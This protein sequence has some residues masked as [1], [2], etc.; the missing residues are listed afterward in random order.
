[1]S[2]VSETIDFVLAP[3]VLRS[4]LGAAVLGLALYSRTKPR[5]KGHVT[6]GLCRTCSQNYLPPLVAVFGLARIW[7]YWV[8][9]AVPEPYLVSLLVT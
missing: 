9:N 7:L 4:I 3:T 5:H 2:F 6:W 1:M 8:N